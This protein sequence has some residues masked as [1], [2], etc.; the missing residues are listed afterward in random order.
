MK[1]CSPFVIPVLVWFSL[2]ALNAQHTGLK[3]TPVATFYTDIFNQGGAESATFD[4]D[5]KRLFFANA[6]SNTIGI[7]NLSNPASP[8]LVDSIPLAT[9]GGK[10]RDVATFNG[11]V[12]VALEGTFKTANGKVVLFEK[13]G[14]LR[15]QY[16]VGA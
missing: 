15:A 13:N 10:V 3:L 2:S 12:A 5:G 6:K 1:K 11:M 4:K 9:Y 8:V 7:L 16:N 14:S